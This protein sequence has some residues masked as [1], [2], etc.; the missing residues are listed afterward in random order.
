MDYNKKLLYGFPHSHHIPGVAE[1]ET[2]CHFITQK[3]HSTFFKAG[4][5]KGELIFGPWLEGSVLFDFFA[6]SCRILF[7]Q[8]SDSSHAETFVQTIFNL[9]SLSSG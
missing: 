5:F 3:T 6:D 2:R 4:A 8:P 7:N 1:I 9:N